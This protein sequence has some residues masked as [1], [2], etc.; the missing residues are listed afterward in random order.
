MKSHNIIVITKIDDIYLSEISFLREITT[1][2][3]TI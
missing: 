1:S 2:Y 3:K